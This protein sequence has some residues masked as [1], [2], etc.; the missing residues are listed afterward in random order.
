MMAPHNGSEGFL[1]ISCA[2]INAG[3]HLF[4][5][6]LKGF[7]KRKKYTMVHQILSVIVTTAQ[8]TIRMFTSLYELLFFYK[9][10]FV[11]MFKTL[12]QLV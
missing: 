9:N 4:E 6:V 8:S 12:V 11:F 5:N 1:L 2:T 10:E 7:L 3:A